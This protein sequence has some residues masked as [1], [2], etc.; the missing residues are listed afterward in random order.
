MKGNAMIQ[1]KRENVN[2]MEI[3]RFIYPETGETMEII[4][5][6][7]GVL[8][9][10]VFRYGEKLEPVICSINPADIETARY[11]FVNSWLIPW[12]NRIRQGK[13]ECFQ[14]EYVAGGEFVRDEYGNVLHGFVFREIFQAIGFSADSYEGRIKLRYRYD[15]SNPF[16]PFPFHLWIRYSFLYPGRVEVEVAVRNTGKGLLPMTMGWH[17]YFF[18]E[19]NFEE[20]I[21]DAPVMQAVKLDEKNIPLPGAKYSERNE[22]P[23]QIRKNVNRLFRLKPGEEVNCHLVHRTDRKGIR[24]TWKYTDFP[25]LMVYTGSEKYGIAVEPMSGSIDAFNNKEG[26]RLIRPG[27]YHTAVI[28]IEKTE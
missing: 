12:A 1:L 10:L 2:N 3:F 9:G 21:L 24:L 13:Y 22:S 17:P 26:L 19:T 11:H 6:A 4:P 27:E 25:Y 8:S 7:G 23:V 18:P 16:Y 20:W 15:G 5:A 14:R 28:R